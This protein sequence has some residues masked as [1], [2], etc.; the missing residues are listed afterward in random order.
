MCVFGST[1]ATSGFGAAGAAVWTALV[2]RNGPVWVWIIE[3]DDCYGRAGFNE[4]EQSRP[5]RLAVGWGV[6]AE[7]KTY[8]SDLPVRPKPLVRPIHEFGHQRQ[9]VALK[10]ESFELCRIQSVS[11]Q[12]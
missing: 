12:M 2:R 11:N 10:I 9:L 7:G 1:S 4:R 5:I 3:A 8:L 6:P